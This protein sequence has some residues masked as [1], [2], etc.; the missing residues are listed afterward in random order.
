MSLHNYNNDGMLVQPGDK[1]TF[2]SGLGVEILLLPI[3]TC[4]VLASVSPGWCLV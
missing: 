1:D 3:P 4:F 2:F